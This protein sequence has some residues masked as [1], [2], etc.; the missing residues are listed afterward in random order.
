MRWQSSPCI[1]THFKNSS[2]PSDRTTRRSSPKTLKNQNTRKS[3]LACLAHLFSNQH[4]LAKRSSRH[5]TLT[6]NKSDAEHHTIVVFVLVAFFACLPAARCY[7][8]GEKR[9]S[10]LWRRRSR[11]FST[12]QSLETKQSTRSIARSSVTT[13]MREQQT[14]RSHSLLKLCERTGWLAPTILSAANLFTVADESIHTYIK[15]HF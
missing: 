1:I 11:R 15:S 8:T 13:S 9:R 7:V 5:Q 14:S 6:Y 10:L 12:P 3:F 4:E 2:C